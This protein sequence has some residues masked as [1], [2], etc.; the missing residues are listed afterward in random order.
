[1]VQSRAVAAKRGGWFVLGAILLL[2]P[3]A[4]A[5]HHF[6]Q[7]T[8]A[9]LL[10]AAAIIPLAGLM[11]RATEALADR[12]GSGI[13]GLV[14]S[15]LGNAAELIIGLIALKKGMYDLVKASLTGSIIGNVLFVLGLAIFLGGLRRR[16]QTFGRVAAEQGVA[17]LFVS[18]AA[19]SVPSVF[20]KVV[21]HASD[22]AI[23][24]TSVALA[25]VLLAMYVA[26]LIFSLKTHKEHYADEEAEEHA[27]LARWSWKKIVGAL[28]LSGG[29]IGLLSEVLVGGVEHAAHALHLSPFFVGVVV[30]AIVGNAAEH[31]TAVVMALKNRMNLAVGIALESSKQ[32]ALFV[33]PVL[34]FAGILMGSEFTLTFTML[35]VAAL[36]MTVLTLG[37]LLL[38]G[39]S[40]WLEGV[41]LLGLYAVLAV[42]FYFAV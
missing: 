3:G 33:A 1:M 34:V 11:G 26:G 42:A 19:L 28:A 40:N 14:N 8:L 31:A 4:L 35:E 36:A 29:L 38:D 20:E 13:G 6:H 25:A 39:R 18:V 10:S 2:T 16:E 15:T 37:L 22:H 32:I 7:E 21:D 27:E 9:F 41:Q 23:W 12:A 30:V 5:S 17:M 24:T